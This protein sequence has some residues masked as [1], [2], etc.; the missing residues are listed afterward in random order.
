MVGVDV[1][2]VFL[3]MEPSLS[4]NLL[5]YTPSWPQTQRSA[6]LSEIK[7]MC[8]HTQLACIYVKYT[9]DVPGALRVQRRTMDPK[10]PEL[11]KTIGGGNQTQVFWKTSRCS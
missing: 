10:E 5:Q 7:S 2:F 1:C 9:A 8:Q 4:C 3:T 11:W 6:S